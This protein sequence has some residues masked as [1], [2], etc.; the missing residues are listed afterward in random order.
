ME[1][2]KLISPLMRVW[3]YLKMWFN[4]PKRIKAIEDMSEKVNTLE[5]KVETM[6]KSPFAEYCPNPGCGKQMSVDSTN[7]SIWVYKCTPC[8]KTFRIPLD[9][10]R[11]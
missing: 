5:G 7:W 9:K 3:G 1:Y 2:L 8:N 10:R 4:L 6:S 11:R